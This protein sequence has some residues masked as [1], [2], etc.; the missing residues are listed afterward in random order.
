M[1]KLTLDLD[2]NVDGLPTLQ[3]VQ[4]SIEATGDSMSRFERIGAGAFERIGHRVTDF[5]SGLVSKGIDFVIDNVG[6][7]IELASTKAEALSKVNVLLGDSAGIVEE[8]S[9]D[10]ATAVGLSS[11]AY[12]EAAGTLANLTTNLGFTQEEAAGMSV[13]MIQLAADMA[14][15]HDADPSDVI[16]AMGSGFRGESEPLKQ[17][18]VF[19][20]EAAVQAKAVELGLI[21]TT[22]ALAGMDI[23]TQQNI[24]A[25][26]TYAL[27]LEQTQAAQGD[28]ARTADSLANQQRRA[29]AIQEEAWTKL[30]EALT[31]IANALVPLLTEVIVGLVDV[32]L[33]IVNAV[34]DW[35]KQNKGLVDTISSVAQFLGDVLGKA[36]GLVMRLLGALFDVIGRVVNIF[37]R[38]GQVFLDVVGKVWNFVRPF[39]EAIQRGLQALG[40]AFSKIF[41]AISNTV[42]NA[43]NT[44]VS[45][46]TQLW[47]GLQRIGGQ[48]MD[49]LGK[50]FKPL[51]DSINAAID[52]VK[53]AWNAFARFWNGIE[54]H[55]PKIE[56]P[57]PFGGFITMGGGSIGLPKLPILAKGGIA[58]SATLALI[59]ERGP[60]AIIPLDRLGGLGGNTYYV[61]VQAG[62]GDPV[63]IGRAVVDTIG[64]Y[65]RANGRDWRSSP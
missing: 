18:G 13:D 32:I 33:G 45:I 62:V 30:G 8:A 42:R 51:G 16:A 9:R 20:S 28:V 4:G 22:A 14:S 43:I 7:S 21:P 38:L 39:F 50:L 3:K 57:N 2:I 53:Q 37:V 29:A 35:M 12:L 27:M 46:F 48:I 56:I 17:F 58:T 11:G 36:L 10:A 5:A 15:F 24:K 47:T 1:A 65:E 6:N 61:T 31:P 52:I 44:V 26:A 19:L 40:D 64:A 41:T 63:A 60:E 59:G 25:Q 54:L 55:I 49:F 23:A 34:Q